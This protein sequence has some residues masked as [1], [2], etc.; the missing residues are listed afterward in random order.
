MALIERAAG[1][2]RGAVRA[3]QMVHQAAEVRGT[4]RES[5][6]MLL[7][8][9]MTHRVARMLEERLPGLV[10]QLRRH[11]G[12]LVRVARIAADMAEF[13]ANMARRQL[14]GR[15]SEPEFWRKVG[16]RAGPVPEQ[17][18]RR[19]QTRRHGH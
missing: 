9:L 1:L 2:R 11:G 18:D 16:Q 12:A 7:E 14:V 17:V 6:S 15:Q 4:A 3:A 8:R 10:A 5:R 13:L 19:Q